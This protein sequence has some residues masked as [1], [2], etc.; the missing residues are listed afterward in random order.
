MLPV[1]MARVLQLHEPA[2]AL[3]H[4]QV[5]HALPPVQSRAVPP[6]HA[7]PLQVWPTVQ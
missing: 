1:L 7:P 3:L 5:R 2:P 4:V 6:L